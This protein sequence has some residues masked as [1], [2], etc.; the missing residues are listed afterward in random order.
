MRAADAARTCA[1]SAASTATV[2]SGIRQQRDRRVSARQP[3]GHDARADDAR[4]SSNEPRN[5]ANSPALHFKPLRR[6][7]AALPIS[8]RRSC[9]LA[10]SSE[11]MG[12]LVKIL[13]RLSS[14]RKVRRNASHFS[15]SDPSTA[16]GSSTPQC[17]VI[18]W[19][20][21][22]GQISA[23]RVVADG[24]DEIERRRAGRGEFVPALAAQALGRT[25]SCARAIRAR[26]DAPCPW[27]AAGAVTDELAAAP[28]IDQ[29]LTPGCCAR[30]C[31]CR[32]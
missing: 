10:R 18:G 9:S 19:P 4:P 1:I 15:V 20:G 28:V 3:L 12:R 7:R 6:W 29:R 26:S 21:Q 13:M 22:T 31:R 11:R 16:A 5:F 2:A 8:R 25:S 23:R 14:S 30:S 27:G 32:E 24:E 17:A